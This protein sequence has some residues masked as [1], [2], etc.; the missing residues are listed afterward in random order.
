[1]S[2]DTQGTL[3]GLVLQLDIQAKRLDSGE[4]CK[5]KAEFVPGLGADRVVAIGNGANDEEMLRHAALGIAV[6]GVE[7]MAAKCLNAADIIVPGMA[8]LDLL[9]Y[10]KRL[11]ATLR[12]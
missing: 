11:L 2:A 9:I 3:T 10:P 5:Q 1:V 8:A 7:G 6:L 12:A 4:E